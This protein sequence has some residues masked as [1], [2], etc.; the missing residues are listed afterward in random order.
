[1]I[2]IVGRRELTFSLQRRK[3]DVEYLPALFPIGSTVRQM[4]GVP[5]DNFVWPIA[6]PAGRM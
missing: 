6:A 2:H 5:T 3:E 4:N 1:M